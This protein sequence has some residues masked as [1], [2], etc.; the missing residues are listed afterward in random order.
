MQFRLKRS[1]LKAQGLAS[2]PEDQMTPGDQGSSAK[3]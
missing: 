1:E 2:K 3:S